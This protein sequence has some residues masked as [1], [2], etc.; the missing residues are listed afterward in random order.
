MMMILAMMML[1]DLNRAY[2]L[3]LT[4]VSLHILILDTPFCPQKREYLTRYGVDLFRPL[5]SPRE[6]CTLR[7]VCKIS[8]SRE[9]RYDIKLLDHWSGGRHDAVSATSVW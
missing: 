2:R 6:V 7:P 8:S 5:G 4:F 9:L 1:K 3:D